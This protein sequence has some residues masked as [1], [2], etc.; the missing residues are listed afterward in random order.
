MN[1]TPNQRPITVFDPNNP[2]AAPGAP[3]VLGS[4]Q[5]EAASAIIQANAAGRITVDPTIAPKQEQ[6]VLQPFPDGSLFRF[7]PSGKSDGSAVLVDANNQ[8]VALVKSAFLADFLC[9]GA[10]LFFVQLKEMQTQV[11]KQTEPASTPADENKK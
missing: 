6:I 9:R 2:P 4:P 1:N 3:L 11:P 8:A 10:H 5:T 7:G